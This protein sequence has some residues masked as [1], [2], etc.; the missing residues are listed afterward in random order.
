[1]MKPEI[2]QGDNNLKKVEKMAVTSQETIIEG[3]H[4]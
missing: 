3:V 1:M 4:P 2:H